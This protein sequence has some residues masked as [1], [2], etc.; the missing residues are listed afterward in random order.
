[1]KLIYLSGRI[2][3]I[4]WLAIFNRGDRVGNGSVFILKL[5]YFVNKMAIQQQFITV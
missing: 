3:A 1:M 5:F 2:K 4:D